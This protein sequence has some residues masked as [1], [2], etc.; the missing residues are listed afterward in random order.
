M[1]YMDG[2]RIDMESGEEYR[3]PQYHYKMI[4]K[5]LM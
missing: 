2:E 5:Q 3:S 1:V 4:Q